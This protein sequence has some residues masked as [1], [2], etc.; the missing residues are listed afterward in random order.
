M[1]FD[2]IIIGGGLTGLTCA[3]RLQKNGQRCAVISSGQSALHFSSGSFDLLN[4]T[5]QG[6]E[7]QNPTEA[8][9]SLNEDHP[10]RKL[11]N[12]FEAYAE[13]AR[14]QLISCGIEV[15]GGAAKN[16]FRFTPMGTLRPTWLS[17]EEFETLKAK[18]NLSNRKILIANFAGFLDFNTIFVLEAFQKQGFSCDATQLQIEAV[19][20]LRE[21]P[22]EMRAANIAKA[23]ENTDASNELISKLNLVAKGYDYV[24]LPAVFGFKTTQIIKRLKKEVAAEIMIL[25]TMPPSVPGVRTQM[26]LRREFERMG[27]VY[28]LGD[29]V[30]KAEVENGKVMAIYTEN[31]VEIPLK[32]DNYVLATGHFFSG[33]ITSTID[34]VYEPIFGCDVE[35]QQGRENWY[36]TEFK[37]NHNYA[38]FGVKTDDDFRAKASDVSFQNLYAAGAILCGANSIKEG[39][40]G[41][42]SMLTALRVADI[43]M[44]GGQK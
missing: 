28:M 26:T 10:Y 8:V 14:E 41:G 20:R 15:T 9:A 36:S 19:N 7:I 22:T 2:T 38:T 4:F 42:V 16:H 6:E 3:L 13:M 37:E 34:S 12:Q 1:K 35:Y 40:G 31:H 17:F 23:L 11:G 24:A 21:N 32:A 5:E 43:I 39:S 44:K 18:E 27:G 29:T 25:P 33:G 30:Q